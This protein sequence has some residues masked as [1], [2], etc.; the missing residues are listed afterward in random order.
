VGDLKMRIPNQTDLNELLKN[1]ITRAFPLGP[2]DTDNIKEPGCAAILY[3]WQNTAFAKLV[4]GSHVII[5]RRGSGKSALLNAIRDSSIFVSMLRSEAHGKTFQESNE[6]FES[7]LNSLP[8]FV[9]RLSLPS[10]IFLLKRKLLEGPSRPHVE[11]VSDYWHDRIFFKIGVEIFKKNASL[12][13][14]LPKSSRDY[15]NGDDV[16]VEPRPNQA[17]IITAEDFADQIK[18]A[19]LSQKKRISITVDSIEEYLDDDKVI[20][21]GL[22]RCAGQLISQQRSQIDLKLC[23]PSEHY[24]AII[25][26]IANQDKDVTKKQFLHWSSSELMHIAAH[27]LRIFLEIY[28][29]NEYERVQA[30]RLHDRD[31]LH[32]FWGRYLPKTI[33]NGFNTD[34]TSLRYI[35]RHTQ[36]LPRQVIMILNSAFEDSNVF[37][38]GQPIDEKFVVRAVEKNEE[39]FLNT[40]VMMFE[41]QYPQLDLIL[42]KVLPRLSRVIRYGRLQ[43]LWRE[44][45]KDI[46]LQMGFRDFLDFQRM[47]LAI[48]ALGVVDNASETELYISG[49]FEF[50]TEHRIFASDKD[51]FCVHPIFSRIYGCQNDEDK[52]SKPILTRDIER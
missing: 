34:E 43:V 5:G 10:E 19:L 8:H 6:I 42:Q 17:S 16:A 44:E 37:G 13:A 21:A 36:M 22:F 25:R 40:I 15:I 26:S 30:L 50:N 49:R 51:L 11:I 35:L 31:D 52:Y 29:P 20:I 48:G 3:E 12:W 28:Y 23:L 4:K 33:S 27:R 41:K 9:L 18:F 32:Q 1:H 14:T 7:D 24:P 2:V 47:M 38:T 39:S 46:M 45:A